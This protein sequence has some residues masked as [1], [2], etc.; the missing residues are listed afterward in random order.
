MSS[1]P[2]VIQRAPTFFYVAALLFF[3]GS[4]IITYVE[5]QAALGYGE[6]GNAM[7]RSVLLRGAFNAALDSVYIAANGV[8]A[9]ILLAI[10][11]NGRGTAAGADA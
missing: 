1:L 8:L 11:E 3:F 7:L 6:H 5:T 9:Q 4:V 10:W 2:R